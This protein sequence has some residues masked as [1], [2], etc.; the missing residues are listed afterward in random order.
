[1]TR[2]GGGGRAVALRTFLLTCMLTSAARPATAGRA[3]SAGENDN[4]NVG[5]N[6][7]GGGKGKDR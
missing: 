7:N 5:G 3:G 2:R 4:G 6:G 1:M